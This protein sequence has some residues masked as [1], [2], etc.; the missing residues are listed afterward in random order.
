MKTCCRPAWYAYGS[1][2]GPASRGR[3][4]EHWFVAVEPGLER[5]LSLTADLH[6]A[7][8]TPRTIRVTWPTCHDPRSL[9]SPAVAVTAIA[10]LY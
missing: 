2:E 4:D 3:R 7:T 5:A 10:V 9:G 8:E 1:Q 6:S